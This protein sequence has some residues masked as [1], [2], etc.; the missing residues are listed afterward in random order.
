[1]K[2][3]AGRNSGIDLLRV[4]LM[5][6]ICMLHAVNYSGLRYGFE[7]RF[8]GWGV[9]GFA[10]ISGYYGVRFRLSKLI[11]LWM[12][13]LFCVCVPFAMISILEGRWNVRVFRRMLFG[14]WY[15]NAYTMLMLLSPLLNRGL[16]RLEE[17]GRAWVLPFVLLMFWSWGSEAYWV[18]ECVPRVPGIGGQSFFTLFYAYVIAHWVRERDVFVDLC[19]DKGKLILGF[20]FCV[21]CMPVFGGANG[22][23]A[24]VFVMLLFR[25]FERLTLPKRCARI[26]N[27]IVPSIFAVYL[28]HTN[29]FGYKCLCRISF[30]VIDLGCPQYVA[31]ASAAALV[32]GGCV[33]ID[34]MRR[35]A[36]LPMRSFFVRIDASVDRRGCV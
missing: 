8:W 21:C 12:L 32:F 15:L 26:V 14:N 25:F 9:A 6:A 33:C 16:D 2:D 34:W 30:W 17:M 27:V 7:N 22:F 18:R 10:F 4:V 29:A 3:V 35:M 19:N 11:R 20:L 31:F 36:L 13:A 24:L 28:L 5:L 23:G 1:M